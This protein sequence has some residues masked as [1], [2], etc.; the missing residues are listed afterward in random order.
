MAYAMDVQVLSA[1]VKDERV[2]G[3]QVLLQRNGEQTQLVFTS[4][5]GMASIAGMG[6]VQ[7]GSGHSS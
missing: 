6:D 1:V 5:D 7:D 2:S 3:A 4:S